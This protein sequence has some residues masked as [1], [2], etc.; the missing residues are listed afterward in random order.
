MPQREGIG[1][2]RD[3]FER[4]R[5]GGQKG[6]RCV[7]KVERRFVE[8]TKYKNQ[9]T[10]WTQPVTHDLA[11]CPWEKWSYYATMLEPRED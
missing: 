11:I 2:S 10:G 1:A 9:T 5:K 7:I 3:N 8:I 6:R 4:E